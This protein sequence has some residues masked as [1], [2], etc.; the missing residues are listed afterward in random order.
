MARFPNL[1]TCVGDSATPT[2]TPPLRDPTGELS[3][4]NEVAVLIGD[5]DT[6]ETD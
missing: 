4:G 2:R 6:W 5:R 1:L 3:D